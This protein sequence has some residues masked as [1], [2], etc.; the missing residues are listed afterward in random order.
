MV[1]P[2]INTADASIKSNSFRAGRFILVPFLRPRV[3]RWR[4]N[5]FG[6]DF[7]GRTGQCADLSAIERKPG[8]AICPEVGL[9]TQHLFSAEADV[10]KE[11]E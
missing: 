5:P 8:S 4:A 6:E 7:V 1:T 2:S 10:Q 9:L 11:P 3:V